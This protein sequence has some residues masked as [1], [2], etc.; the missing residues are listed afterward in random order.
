MWRKHYKACDYQTNNKIIETNIYTM[1]L[2]GIE[3]IRKYIKL[4]CLGGTRKYQSSIKRT[5]NAANGENKYL[6]P[7]RFEGSGVQMMIMEMFHIAGRCF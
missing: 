5:C 1:W 3:R 7:S 4:E 2:I 6:S